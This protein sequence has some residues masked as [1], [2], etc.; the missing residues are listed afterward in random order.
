MLFYCLRPERAIVGKPVRK[1]VGL[2][3]TETSGVDRAAHLHDGFLVMKSAEEEKNTQNLV[4]EALG[5]RKSEEDTLSEVVENNELE[6]AETAMDGENSPEMSLEEE[7]KSYKKKYAELEKKMADMMP[8]ETK[9]SYEN[10]PEEIAKS[11]D[12]MPEEQAEVFAKAFI[13]QQEE[14]AKA[15]ESAAQERDERLDAEAISKSRESFSVLGVDH[16]TV[17]PALRRIAAIDENLAKSIETALVSAD[18]QLTEAG[19]LKEFGT[20]K[21]VSSASVYEEAKTLAKSLVEGGVVK[22]IEQGIEK[23]LDSNPELA[24]RYYK[25]NN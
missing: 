16:D 14:L 17:A 9:K 23:V 19:L 18:A 3:V 8:A 24:K 4:L 2:E 7:L 11:L 13:A 6:K 21:A 15:K 10:L 22:T 1:L 5:L 25:E 12:G 20:A